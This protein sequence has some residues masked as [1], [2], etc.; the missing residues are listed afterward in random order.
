MSMHQNPWTAMRSLTRDGEVAKRKLRAGHDPA[1]RRVRAAVPAADRRLPGPGG[2]RRAARRWRCRCCSRSSSTRWRPGADGSKSTVVTVA[3]GVAVLA[4][5]DAGLTLVAALAAPSRIGEGLIYDLRTQVFAHVQR[6]PVAFFTRTQTG[7]L[8]TR[9]NND[10]DR[11]PAGVHLDAVRRG[12]QR[13]SAWSSCSS[14]CSACPGRSPCV[15]W[16]CCRCSCCPPGWV[17]RRLQALTR[18][19]DAAQR[20]DGHD[21]DRAVQRRRRAAGQAVRP[22]ATRRTARS[23]AR[24]AGSATSAS[25]SRCT[26][27]VLHRADPGRRRWRPRWSTASAASSPSTARSRSARWSR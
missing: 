6:M 14:R 13:R 24:P 3:L 19:A 7:A 15:A 17:G 18:E 23:P 2:P 1:D 26:P 20:R 27:G 22:A 12:L 10:V 25:A 4:L 8:V 5:V 21:D 11:R 16:C 9:L